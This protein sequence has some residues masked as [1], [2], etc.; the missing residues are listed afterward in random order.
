MSAA[1]N[2]LWLQSGGC[3]GCSMSLLNA[4]ATDFAG[5]LRAAL[6]RHA[7]HMLRW[8]PSAE[9]QLAQRLSRQQAYAALSAFAGVAQRTLVEPRGVRLREVDFVFD[10]EHARPC[11]GGVHG[12]DNVSV[13]LASS[14]G[15]APIPP[16]R[17]D[18]PLTN[19]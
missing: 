4:D 17:D 1:L 5:Q 12:G 10:D 2:L 15:H 16:P 8:V 3:G 9:E 14:V 6:A 19:P 13:L 18:S 7:D 11:R